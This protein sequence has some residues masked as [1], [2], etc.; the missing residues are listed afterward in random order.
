V[1]TR[2]ESNDRAASVE[3][4]AADGLLRALLVTPHNPMPDRWSDIVREL[5]T[6]AEK[7]SAVLAEEY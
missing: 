5:S 4:H 6:V 2:F 1:H 7:L 3:V